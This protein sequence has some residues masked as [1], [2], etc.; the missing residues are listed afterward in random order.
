MKTHR[1]N[2]W[3][4]MDKKED[5]LHLNDKMRARMGQA[6]VKYFDGETKRKGVLG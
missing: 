5:M 4:V 2:E 1:W 3:R 6:V